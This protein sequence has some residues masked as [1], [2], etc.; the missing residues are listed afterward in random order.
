MLI[1]REQKRYSA[2][3]PMN[4]A[5]MECGERVALSDVTGH[6]RPPYGCRSLHLFRVGQIPRD[7]WLDTQIELSQR[8]AIAAGERARART[9]QPKSPSRGKGRRRLFDAVQR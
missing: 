3:T 7:D 1:A 9:R 2:G 6:N 5:A 8:D 4:G